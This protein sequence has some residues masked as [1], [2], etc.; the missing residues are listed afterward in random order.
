MSETAIERTPGPTR[1]RSGYW[2]GKGWDWFVEDLGPYVLVGFLAV[3]VLGLSQGL[4]YGPAAALLA[5]SGLRRVRHTADREAASWSE[6][7]QQD[8]TA[9]FRRFLPALLSGL[10]ILVFTCI[11]LVFLIVPGIVIFTMYLFTFHFMLDEGQDFWE[12]MESSRRLVSRD[13]LGFSLFTVL[14]VV[15]NLLGLAFFVVGSFATIMVTSLAVAAAYR[16]CTGVAPE[17]EPLT[18]APIV[19][20]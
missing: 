16:D 7:V 12:A 3:V 17:P 9:S 6:R 15:V 8:L 4:L 20:E 13:Y 5:A 2:L 18:E 19:I 11:G 1:V 10:L 14:L